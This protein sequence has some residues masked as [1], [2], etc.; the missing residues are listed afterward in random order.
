MHASNLAYLDKIV[1][2]IV[3]PSYVVDDDMD[4]THTVRLKRGFWV[5]TNGTRFDRPDGIED[6]FSGK[7]NHGGPDHQSY[8]RGP[9][10]VA[11][12]YHYRWKSEEEY[13]HKV[14][15]RGNSLHPRF[16][17]GGDGRARGDFPHCGGRL[18][19]RGMYKTEKNGGTFDDT[20]WRHLKRLVPKYAVYDEDD[21]RQ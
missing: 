5:D 18:E 4:W 10:D 17:L 6:H 7:L 16:V 12:F 1:K 2:V 13:R 3:R 14:C 20:A 8:D 11:Q 21:T 15:G 19:K 9:T